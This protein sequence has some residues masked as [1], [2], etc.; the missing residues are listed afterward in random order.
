LIVASTGDTAAAGDRKVDLVPF[1]AEFA[2]A[3]E[4][5]QAPDLLGQVSAYL[6]Q[7]GGKRLRPAL[8]L[9]SAQAGPL[10]AA[11][12]D[13]ALPLAVACEI[14]HTATLVHDDVV[15]QAVLRRGQPT[16]AARWGT[17]VA[18]LAGDYLF[19]RALTMIAKLGRPD[20][21]VRLGEV[22]Q[23]MCEAELEQVERAYDVT[24]TEA[25]YL[26]LVARKSG[27]LIGECCRS[28]AEL[29][30]ATAETAE[31]LGRFGRALGVAFQIA[32]DI[33]D[34]VAATEELGKPTGG[35]IGLGL[36]TLP[37]IAAVRA[38]AE[39][40][41]LFERRLSADGDRQRALEL[42]RE[43]TAVAY[44]RQVAAEHVARALAELAGLPPG[45]PRESLAAAAAFAVRRS[46]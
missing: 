3:L 25:E 30:G 20:I 33:L 21:S 10:G 9:L 27:L 12:V 1:E 44:A 2:A 43:G 39:A 29:A 6:R 15:D 42:V 46:R 41:R 28:G 23:G 45:E 34:V 5:G 32:D 36:L 14:L 37:V 13:R 31:R 4:T 7:S 26:R 40:R 16:V 17:R 19:A 18:V 8:V 38:S 11:G 35:D 24:Y 22:V